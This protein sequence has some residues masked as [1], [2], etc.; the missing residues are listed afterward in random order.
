MD[1]L[2]DYVLLEKYIAVFLF[3]LFPLTSNADSRA[4]FATGTVGIVKSSELAS[5]SVKVIPS[6]GVSLNKLVVQKNINSTSSKPIFTS[7]VKGI[8]AT[9]ALKK[10]TDPKAVDPSRAAKKSSLLGSAAVQKE[11]N[12]H[13]TPSQKIQFIQASTGERKVEGRFEFWGLR[14][15]FEDLWARFWGHPQVEKTQAVQFKSKH[16]NSNSVELSALLAQDA[17]RKQQ[18]RSNLIRNR[19]LVK[20]KQL[21]EKQLKE[22]QLK[23]K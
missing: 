14:K 1:S 22:K 20:A 7:T 9:V 2:K 15:W 10:S 18:A 8:G 13:T 3:F 11:N 16:I 5:R 4:D 23:F 17:K 21:K 12:R 19:A 6:N